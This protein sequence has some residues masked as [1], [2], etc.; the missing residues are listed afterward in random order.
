MGLNFNTVLFFRKITY[1]VINEFSSI[2]ILLGFQFSALLFV[3]TPAKCFQEWVLDQRLM[4]Y[5]GGNQFD[6]GVIGHRILDGRKI[7][8]KRL[9]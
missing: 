9:F 8:Q 1:S 3:N 5:A 6:V 4:L 7:K 2:W